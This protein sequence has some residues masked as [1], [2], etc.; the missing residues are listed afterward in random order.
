MR[1][2][3][4]LLFGGAAVFIA[5]GCAKAEDKAP[6]AADAQQA[7]TQPPQAEQP[8]T[9]QDTTGWRARMQQNHNAAQSIE[10][11]VSRLT[12]DLALTPAQQETVRKLAWDHN[13]KIQTILDTAPPTL[14]RED[15][16]VQVHAISKEFHDSVNAILT[17]RQLELMKNMVGRLDSGQERRRAP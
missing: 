4:R 13:K 10:D 8:Q 1:S 2:V 9:L 7:Q 3:S 16:T 6:P 14:T 5:A 15:F 17:P 11:Q 12:K